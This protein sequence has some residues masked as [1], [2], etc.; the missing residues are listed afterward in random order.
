MML[1]HEEVEWPLEL[2]ADA[3]YA[4]GRLLDREPCTRYRNAHP[5]MCC[6]VCDNVCLVVASSSSCCHAACCMPSDLLRVAARRITAAAIASLPFAR[7]DVRAPRSR[8]PRC[9][10]LRTPE[11]PL[12]LPL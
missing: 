5:I 7:S 10:C 12:P 3:A 8:Q 2:P 6:R 1:L 4:M 11:Y 9:P